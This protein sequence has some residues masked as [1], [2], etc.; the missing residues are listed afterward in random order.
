[1]LKLLSCPSWACLNKPLMLMFFS[2]FLVCV[3]VS[4]YPL[5]ERNVSTIQ[6]LCPYMTTTEREALIALS[7]AELL[8]WQEREQDCAQSKINDFTL[9]KKKAFIY[10]PT[11]GTRYLSSKSLSL[12]AH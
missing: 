10:T 1:M 5:S 11:P 4:F 3:C 9:K 2:L 6:V 8:N 12:S 7:I